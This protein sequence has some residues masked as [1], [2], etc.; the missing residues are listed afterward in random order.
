MSGCNYA[1]DGRSGLRKIS[2]VRQLAIVFI[3]SPCRRRSASSVLLVRR[4]VRVTE[5]A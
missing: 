3:P 5:Q 1:E 4:Q 2:I